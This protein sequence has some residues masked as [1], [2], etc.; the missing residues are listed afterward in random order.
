MRLRGTATSVAVLA[1]LAGLAGGVATVASAGGSTDEMVSTQLDKHLCKTKGGGKFV[2]I[3]G[4]PG[5]K[6][7]RRLLP[8][9]AWMVDKY[10]LFITDGYSTDP[11][12]ARNGEHPI[13]LAADIV[14]NKSK[15]GTWRRVTKLARKAEP[16]QNEPIPPWR[17]VG[18]NGDAGH[19][20]GNHLHLSWSHNLHTKP[21]HPV[22]TVYTRE[23]PDDSAVTSEEP[24]G[25]VGSGK[26][27]YELPQRLYRGPTEDD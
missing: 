22:R 14:P 5:E 11:V 2:K 4:F 26:R 15:G 12:H 7:D 8:D 19:G 23:C 6:I 27:A 9:I 17:W 16:H 20:R 10:N 3:P 13:G 24:S 21:K 18:Y 25:G 1:A